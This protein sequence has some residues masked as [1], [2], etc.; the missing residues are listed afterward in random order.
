GKLPPA[1]FAVL[2][3]LARL[4]AG[5]LAVV[6]GAHSGVDGDSHARTPTDVPFRE[7]RPVSTTAP[8][9]SLSARR[10]WRRWQVAAQLASCPWQIAISHNSR[11]VIVSCVRAG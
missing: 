6:C 7:K 9:R 4:Q 10:S 2:S 8:P 11:C 3:K 1:P 5:V